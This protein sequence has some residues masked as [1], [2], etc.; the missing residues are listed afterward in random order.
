MP[1]FTGTAVEPVLTAAPSAPVAGQTY[2]NS[3]TGDT[4]LYNGTSWISSASGKGYV[5]HGAAAG[6]AR[7]T[8]Y[9]S[10]EWIGSVSP[11]NAVNGD[12]WVNTA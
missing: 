1:K 2:Y 10:V 11:T 3:T 4:Y 7:P 9:V 6:T 12:T 5:N 8:G